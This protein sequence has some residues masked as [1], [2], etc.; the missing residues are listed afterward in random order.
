LIYFSRIRFTNPAAFSGV[1][2]FIRYFA[3]EKHFYKKGEYVWSEAGKP[4]RPNE[5]IERA[6]SIVEFVRRAV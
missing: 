4:P 3:R 2:P 5:F 1:I 6:F